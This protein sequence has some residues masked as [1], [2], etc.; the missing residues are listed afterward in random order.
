MA[1][2]AHPHLII[3]VAVRSVIA[4]AAAGVRS[5]DSP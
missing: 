4:A 5:R 2:A 3:T 1:K